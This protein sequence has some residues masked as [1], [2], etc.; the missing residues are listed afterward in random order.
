MVR[1]GGEE[2]HEM[3][4]TPEKVKSLALCSLDKRHLWHGWTLEQPSCTYEEIIRKIWVRLFSVVE[5]GWDTMGL[6]WNGRFLLGLRKNFFTLR[7][8]EH[9]KRLPRESVHFLSLDVFKI[10]RGKA[11]HNVALLTLLWAW[12]WNKDLLRSLLNWVTLWSCDC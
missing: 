9:W 2:E 5:E 11:L 8:V 10:R 1:L 4:E 3:G 6:N 7:T 12:G